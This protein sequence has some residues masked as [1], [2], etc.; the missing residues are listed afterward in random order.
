MKVLYSVILA[1]LVNC[2]QPSLSNVPLNAPSITN[3][4]FLCPDLTHTIENDPETLETFRNR[5]SFSET[6]ENIL[7]PP[8]YQ[9]MC[10]N[11]NLIMDYN[12]DNTISRHEL[13]DPLLLNQATYFQKWHMVPP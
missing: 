10:P 2:Q 4:L 12:R 11:L 1:V 9:Y 5:L 13:S 6:R 3:Q 7:V 8:N